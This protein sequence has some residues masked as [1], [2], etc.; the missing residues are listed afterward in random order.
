MTRENTMDQTTIETGNTKTT[1]QG[2]QSQQII[3][4][5]HNTLIVLREDNARSGDLG[6]VWRK[7]HATQQAG[8]R[9]LLVLLQ[10][11]K[12]ENQKH[13]RTQEF[14]RKI[15]GTV[16]AWFP[17]GTIP[18]GHACGWSDSYTSWKGNSHSWILKK[19]NQIRPPT[20]VHG[21]YTTT[22]QPHEHEPCPFHT[23]PCTQRQ[24]SE[25]PRHRQTEATQTRISHRGNWIFTIPK[26]HCLDH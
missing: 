5:N 18:F 26:I 1:Y 12:T 17:T 9:V 19:G 20:D 14:F 21:L 11:P 15:H 23:F 3:P 7:I 8:K 22:R 24:H 25:N 10:G 4:W 6:D 13:R 2:S 16:V